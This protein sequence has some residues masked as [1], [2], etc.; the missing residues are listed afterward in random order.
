MPKKPKQHHPS[1]HE[2]EL[3]RKAL[4]QAKIC[5][6]PMKILR[7]VEAAGY[8]WPF[9][10]KSLNN[11]I[12]GKTG[13]LAP[14]H[15]EALAEVWLRS[16][17]GRALRF[18]NPA[19]KPAFDELPQVLAT[20]KLSCPREVKLAERYFMYHGS[21]VKDDCYTV[22]AI[23]IDAGD[24]H[25]LAVTDSVR[26]M[27][28]V[29]GGV[30]ISRGALTFFDGCPQILLL[31][32]KHNE[33]KFGFTLIVGHRP[34]VAQD[35]MIDKMTGA[36]LTM[37]TGSVVVSRHCLLLREPTDKTD[38]MIA[39]SGAFTVEQLRAKDMARHRKAFDMLKKHLPLKKHAPKIMSDPMLNYVAAPE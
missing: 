19:T 17:L 8:G 22:R 23:Q 24:D 13:D 35:G 30:R 21:Y 6:Q 5:L 34:S 31:P 29:H 20:G 39:Q 4:G 12:N 36:F 32:D 38:A 10:P 25:I 9:D 33:T 28:N 18:L 15:F 26:D 16:P 11:F 27:L 1:D 3:L 14:D 7:T 2:Q 37:T